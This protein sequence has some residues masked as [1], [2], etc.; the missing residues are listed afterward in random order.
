MIIVL[1]FVAGWLLHKLALNKKIDE[2]HRQAM[3]E[4]ETKYKK[5]ENEYKNYK[6]NIAATDKHHEKAV[7]ESNARVKALEGDIRALAEEKNKVRNQLTDKDQ[8]IRRLLQQ[9]TEKD[10]VVSTIKES[11]AKAEEEWAEKLRT[12]NQS[13]TR[14]LSW[15]DKAKQAESEAT[16]AKDAI[17]HAERKKL[18]AELRLKAVSDYAGKIGPLQSELEAKDQVIA[19]LQEQLRS[20]NAAPARTAD[21]S[22]RTEVPITVPEASAKVPDS[23]ARTTSAPETTANVPAGIV[24]AP[25]G[26][27]EDHPVPAGPEPLKSDL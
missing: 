22:A 13:L 20:V 5:V 15:E 21:I 12:A 14:A 3:A 26:I 19:R 6:S 17:G 18:E 9:L 23:P 4:L 25:A 8:E 10:D 24:T 11:R 27:A 7:I 2:R 16:R 1:A